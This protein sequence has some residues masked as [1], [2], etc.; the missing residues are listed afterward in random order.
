M[1]RIVILRGQAVAQQVHVP[2]STLNA[3]ELLCEVVVFSGAVERFQKWESMLLAYSFHLYLPI[4]FNSFPLTCSPL[5]PPFTQSG[6]LRLWGNT[7]STPGRSAGRKRIWFVF[8]AKKTLVAVIL[9]GF[10]EN[11]LGVFDHTN[12]EENCLF[13][14]WKGTVRGVSRD[15]SSG[16]SRAVS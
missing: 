8:A 11:W 12:A 4:F 9:I 14:I 3:G 10:W 6:G 5:P 16:E 1:Y 7:V 2:C 13:K 15:T